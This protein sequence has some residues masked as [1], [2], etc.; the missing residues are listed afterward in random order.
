M[1]YRVQYFNKIDWLFL[2]AILCFLSVLL[3]NYLGFLNFSRIWLSTVPSIYILVVSILAKLNVQDLAYSDY[4]NFRIG[5]ISV[6]TI[7]FLVFSLNERIKL[8]VTAIF[9]FACVALCDKVHHLFNVGYYDIGFTDSHYNF[10][11]F[12]T[13]VSTLAIVG[14]NL[15]LKWII[16]K[17]DFE[18][19]Q[20]V[21]N[22]KEKNNEV[23]AQRDELLAQGDQLLQ[24]K[25]E[26]ENANK[27]IEMQKNWLE[28][29]LV[30]YDY[31]ITQF[32][33]NVCHHLRGPV[34]SLAG[35]IN[36]YSIDGNQR[37]EV[38][39]EHLKK[40]IT[41]L[42]EVV[43]D[44]KHVLDVRKDI[45]RSK[46]PIVLKSIFVEVQKLLST[47]INRVKPALTIEVDG[48]L[49]SAS[50]AA[51]INIFY[52]LIS[53]SLKYR[54]ELRSLEIQISAKRIITRRVTEIVVRDNGLGID[55]NRF[56]SDVFKMYKRFHTHK[57]GK[58]IGLYLAKL[59]VNALG[60]RIRLESR[61]DEYAAFFIELPFEA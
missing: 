24:N 22:L 46:C 16:E 52:N 60:G 59:Q 40:N 28:E 61:V 38:I 10:V 39:I 37:K 57:E 18:N 11:S 36:L 48:V 30:L 8:F 20:L 9:C 6:T 55:L 51:L 26:L 5:L 13:V 29:E 42:D 21:R 44:L 3:F 32:S 58:G 33:Y 12:P 23:A 27:V 49:L 41:H 56:E 31:E 19:Q 34:A 14:G 17:Q 50:Q 1:H 54:N 53:N 47:E 45:F 25:K 43:A 4:Y 15:S 7:P 35:L 2:P